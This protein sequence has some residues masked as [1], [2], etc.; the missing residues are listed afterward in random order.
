MVST[1]V[2]SQMVLASEATGS[3]AVALLPRAVKQVRVVRRL[4]VPEKIG[5]AAE[6]LERATVGVEAGGVQ[7]SG[8]VGVGGGGVGA[9]GVIAVAGCG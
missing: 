1:L 6:G 8:T 5:F 7:A 3:L 9:S 4:P 2:F